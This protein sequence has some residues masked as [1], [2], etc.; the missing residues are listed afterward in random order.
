M[1]QSLQI[2]WIDYGSRDRNKILSVL[3]LLSASEAVD[4]LGIGVVRD[5]F[6]DLL[7]PGISTIQ[8]R[9]KYFLLVPYIMMEL[10]RENNL[11]PKALLDRLSREEIA[12]IAILKK[13][14][15]EGVIGGRAGE[16]L[17]RKPSSIYWNGICTYGIFKNYSRIS[18]NGYLRAVCAMKREKSLLSAAG[19]IDKGEGTDD[20][21]SMYCSTS[22]FW[23]VPLPPENWRESVSIELTNEEAVFLRERIIKSEHSKDSLL[24]HILRNKLYGVVEYDD[25]LNIGSCLELPEDI[26]NIY[27]MA[28][29]FARFIYGANIRYN[30]ILS[31]E[32]NKEANEEW[33]NWYDSV[34]AG[35]IQNYDIS[36]AVN[37]LSLSGRNRARL[38]PFFDKW[39][40]AVLSGDAAV[41][42]K[43]II[44]REIELKGQER[45]KLN[46]EN[47]SWQDGLWLGGG[48]LQ[49]RFRNFRRMIE[50][51]YNG[52]GGDKNV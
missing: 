2:G 40:K 43:L 8:T 31:G 41:M 20:A 34:T 17:Q 52:L 35:F 27:E 16:E 13:D 12:L 45:A 18:L 49:Y 14:N 28:Q 32:Q 23:R 33:D 47:F 46:S 15:A 50:D 19:H 22:G 39:K 29:R 7:F 24:A 10:E 36:E 11:N 4:E 26:R 1:P 51:I 21:D 38:V 9:A 5:G 48:R 44:K 3:S 6:A 30:V 25:I 37:R 42:D